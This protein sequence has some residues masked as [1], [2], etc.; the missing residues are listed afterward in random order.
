MSTPYTDRTWPE[1]KQIMDALDGCGSTMHHGHQGDGFT[2][3]IGRGKYSETAAAMAGF[4]FECSRLY[5]FPLGT[6]NPP[7]HLR[8]DAREMPECNW[9]F[10]YFQPTKETTA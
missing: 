9:L 2:A 4:G 6:D 1:R 8:H 3:A 7:A 10:A 5:T